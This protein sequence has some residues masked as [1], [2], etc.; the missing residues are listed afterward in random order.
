MTKKKLGIFKSTN[1]SM[2]IRVGD[3]VVKIKEERGLLQHFIVICRSR[4]GLNRK[5]CTGTYEF[6]VV[7]RSLFASDGSFLLA[8]DKASIL[9]H[10]EAKLIATKQLKVN[11]LAINQCMY[12]YK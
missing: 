12:H 7:P 11:H 6:G 10:L 5:E 8:Y 2:E 1:A 9:H 3:K 4:P